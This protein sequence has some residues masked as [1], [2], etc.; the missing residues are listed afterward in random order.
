MTDY[1]LHPVGFDLTTFSFSPLLAL[2]WMPL[3]SFL[4]PVA[5]YNVTMWATIVLCCVATDDVPHGEYRLGVH[6]RFPGDADGDRP[7]PG[8]E[9]G[10]QWSA[11]RLVLDVPIVVLPA[12]LQALP[13]S[14]EARVIVYTPATDGI[15]T[16]PKHRVDVRFGEMAS[17]T[18]YRLRPQVITA[19]EDLDLTLYWEAI[20]AEPLKK[21]YKVFTHLLNEAGEIIAQHD[22]EPVAGRRP[23]HTWKRGDKI[24]D[25]HRLVWQA[26]EYAGTATLAV[27]LYDFQTSERLPAYG[28][29]GE[30]LLYD[31]VLLGKVKVE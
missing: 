12:T 18:G 27:G 9:K 25:T 10:E 6:V 20:R 8:W 29:M 5:A 31:R 15:P 1:L 26:Q 28:S 30:R 23:T 3:A 21:D 14:K 2:L 22:G 11:H 17:L 13:I 19:G 7:T 16:E 24:I 4:S